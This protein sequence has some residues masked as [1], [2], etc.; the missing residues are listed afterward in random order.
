MIE[1]TVAQFYASPLNGRVKPRMYSP[2]AEMLGLSP[3]SNPI[4][5]LTQGPDGDFTATHSGGKN[6]PLK[7]DAH[8]GIDPLDFPLP[9]V[10]SVWYVKDYRQ[11][12]TY[13]VIFVGLYRVETIPEIPFPGH[14]LL[15]QWHLRMWPVSLDAGSS[16]TV[17]DLLRALE[18]DAADNSA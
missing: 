18:L 15:T 4:D 3:W 8:I 7:A 6:T 14:S 12:E 2:R 10:G 5:F 1:A 17:A 11:E 9:T 13:K 16:K